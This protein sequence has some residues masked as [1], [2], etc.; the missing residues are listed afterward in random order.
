MVI[1]IIRIKVEANF[2]CKLAQDVDI[3]F[4][5]PKHFLVMC[6]GNVQF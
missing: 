1:E 6:E 4:Y 2:S 5:E 3:I